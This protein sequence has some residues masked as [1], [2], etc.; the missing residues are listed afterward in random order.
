MIFAAKRTWPERP[1]AWEHQGEATS[2]EAF[3]LEFAAVHALGLDTEFVVMEREGENAE[4]QFYKVTGVAPYRVVAAE[5]RRAEAEAKPEEDASSAS[6]SDGSAPVDPFF[7]VGM[8]PVLT[9]VWFLIKVGL[10]AFLVVG[11]IGI[12]LRY[13]KLT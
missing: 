1:K 5:A 6:G 9:S 12:L 3:A 13:L 4:I 2:A 8:R 10:I 7:A 11:S